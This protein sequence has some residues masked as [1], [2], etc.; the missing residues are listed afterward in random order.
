MNL[1]EYPQYKLFKF[2]S[3]LNEKKRQFQNPDTGERAVNSTIISRAYYSAYSYAYHWLEDQHDFK[4]KQKW[5]F[6][7]EGKKYITEH[8]QVRAKLK[9]LNR[10]NVSTNLFELHDLRKKADYHMQI[11]LTEKDVE[12]ALRHM[13]VIFKELKFRK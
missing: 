1:K 10:L 13:N 8:T 2:T 5:E 12:K 7:E 11:P 3:L 4:P 9:S 6:E